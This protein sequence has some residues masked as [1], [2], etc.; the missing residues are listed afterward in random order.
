MPVLESFFATEI[1]LVSPFR[2]QTLLKT[3]GLAT[4]SLKVLKW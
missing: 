1:L 3:T 4:K 2:L